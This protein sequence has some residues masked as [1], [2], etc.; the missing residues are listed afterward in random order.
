MR[1][2]LMK[3]HISPERKQ[4]IGLLNSGSLTKIISF[5]ARL[6]LLTCVPLETVEEEKA[7]TAGRVQTFPAFFC[8]GPAQ[9]NWPGSEITFILFNFILVIFVKCVIISNADPVRP[10]MSGVWGVMDV[11]QILRKLGEALTLNFIFIF[12]I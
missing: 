4:R 11:A 3:D 6:K 8:T 1:C 2:L 7:G 12:S 10:P 9:G 5:G